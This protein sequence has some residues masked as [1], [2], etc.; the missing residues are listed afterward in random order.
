[1]KIQRNYKID[2]NIFISFNIFKFKL[3]KSNKTFYI[4][5]IKY[6]K[7]DLLILL[8]KSSTNLQGFLSISVPKLVH[9]LLTL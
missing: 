2:I 9:M 4:I 3:R 8:I 1:M 6:N 7:I 5:L